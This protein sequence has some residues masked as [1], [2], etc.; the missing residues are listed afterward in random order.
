M[1][2]T[3]RN[4]FA[5]IP[6]CNIPTN[7]WNIRIVVHIVNIN[8]IHFT[9]YSLK[10]LVWCK[11]FLKLKFYTAMHMVQSHAYNKI[12][13]KILPII[14]DIFKFWQKNNQDTSLHFFQIFKKNVYF[15]YQKKRKTKTII[16]II[17]KPYYGFIWS[18]FL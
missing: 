3:L 13:R 17:N 9:L 16:N 6:W 1:K 2:L 7:R 18:L 8:N 11:K 5:T 12:C 14:E 4:P 10:R 15:I